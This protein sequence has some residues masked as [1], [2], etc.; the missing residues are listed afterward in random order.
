MSL[1]FLYPLY[2]AGL[3]AAAMPLVIHLLNRRQRKR[4]RF[5]AVKFILLSQRRIARTYQL[6]NWLLL[7]LRT[8][9]V[10]LLA[11]LLAHPLFQ[12][13]AG[14]FAR[15]APV[16]TVVVVDNSHSM[17]LGEGKGFDRAKDAARSILQA[18][19][20][21][22]RAALIATN[23]TE[24]PKIGF[25]NPSQVVLHD[26]G[27]LG[28]AAGTADFTTSLRQAYELLKDQ[29]GQ[30]ALWLVT[31]LK[32]T[33]WDDFSLSSVG[34]YDPSVPLRIV[35][36]PSDTGSFNAA[37]K[38]I[39]MKTR[40]VATNLPLQLEASVINFTAD[41]IE[42][43]TVQL[44][45]NDKLRDQ[46]VVSLPPNQETQVDFQFRVLQP[47]VHQGHLTL[48]RD[49]LLGTPKYFFTIRTQDRLNALI[50]DGDPQRSLVESE[51]FFVT[52]ALNPSGDSTRSLF[53]PEV[54][55]PGALGGVS[56]SNYQILI[57]ANL[58]RVAP[59]LVPELVEFVEGGG[60]LI[61]FLG[62]K[63]IAADYNREL[64]DSG[65]RILPARLGSETRVP[66]N[67]A[68]KI[69]GMDTAHPA[70]L[71][72]RDELL[73]E[74]LKSAN[75]RAYFQV[76]PTEGQSLLT[77]NEDVPLLLEKKLG[78]GHVLLFT[79]SADA[80][81][82]NLALKT[83]FLPLVQSLI[84]YVSRSHG[85]E[86]DGGIVAGSAKRFSAPR[87]KVGSRLRIIDPARREREVILEAEANGASAAVVRYNQR[88]GIYRVVAEG[89]PGNFSLP[90]LY[91][92]NPP[93]L[94][95]RLQEIPGDQLERKLYPIAHEIM[96]AESLAG[97]GTRMDL[98]TLVVIAVMLTLLWEGW[99]AQ[100]NYE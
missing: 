93:V 42:D 90:S 53:L 57:L 6:R 45:V 82:N 83:A 94:E 52:H 50:I 41:T 77:L 11:L 97:G 12:T 10:V 69:S 79:S 18:M 81:W 95:S 35:R 19:G 91:A 3:I 96:P 76:G 68:V 27:D 47:G 44:Y 58:T 15:G 8:L 4:I 29:G 86:I 80:E 67:E 78:E 73:L 43:V 59:Q 56:L 38:N 40:E 21:E 37:I 100:R 34:Q 13:G 87:N 48:Q 5:P 51:T 23:P 89:G 54:I 2:L 88:A 32:L 61:I 92:V 74:S 9:A 39:R 99:L 65:A 24:E 64:W 72:L 66:P 17:T 71:P 25:K 1:W 75:F 84:A 7:A 20:P 28:P 63:V 22:D 85:G 16:S 55:L 46:R 33:G 31:D 26:L 62:D 14:L 36:T 60:A 30:K 70:L 49:G 98:S